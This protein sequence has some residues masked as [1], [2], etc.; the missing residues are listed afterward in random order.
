MAGDRRY[1]QQGYRDSGGDTRARPDASR[2][3]DAQT[4]RMLGSRTVSRCAECGTRLAT[5][6]EPLGQCP[7]CGAEL[8]ACKQCAHFDPGRRFECT[9]PIPERIPDKLARNDCPHCSLRV[10][11]ERDAS[12]GAMRPEDARQAL[13]NLFKRPPGRGR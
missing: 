11:V 10:T 4:P 6:T 5:L 2:A 1:R 9:Q 8:H 12:S 7:K 13:E 3:S